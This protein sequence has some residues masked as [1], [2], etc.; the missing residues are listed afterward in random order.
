[1][2]ALLRQARLNGRYPDFID[3][4]LVAFSSVEAKPTGGDLLPEPLSERELEVLQLM[5][6]GM[7]SFSTNWYWVQEGLSPAARVVSF[8][9][10]GLGWSA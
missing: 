7:G 2:V 1:M 3:N 6:A 8:D 9:R 4:L 10:A 5:A